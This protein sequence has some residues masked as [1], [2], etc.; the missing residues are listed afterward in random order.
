M[1]QTRRGRE[2]HAESLAAPVRGIVDGDLT[3]GDTVAAPS[4]VSEAE[5]MMWLVGVL[6]LEPQV[7]R[8]V[9]LRR[10]ARETSEEIAGH[11]GITDAAAR[12]R[13][14][15]FRRRH[16]RDLVDAA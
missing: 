13:I 14:S 1:D 8:E 12:Q 15:R 9:I 4:E 5:T 10:L 7:T 3:L 16:A 6:A 2:I 11:L